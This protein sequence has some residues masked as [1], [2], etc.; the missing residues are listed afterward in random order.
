MTSPVKEL[1]HPL[2]CFVLL[3]SGCQDNQL[4]R[5]GVP[6]GGF[7]EEIPNVC[8]FTSTLTIWRY[9]ERAILNGINH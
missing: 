8:A 9:S 2:K 1:S 4:S 7:A 3:L 5:D 6:N